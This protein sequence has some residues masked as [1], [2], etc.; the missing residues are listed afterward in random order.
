MHFKPT[1][2]SYT[3]SLLQTK[4]E[5]LDYFL[6]FDR[7]TDKIISL[8]NPQVEMNIGIPNTACPSPHTVEDGQLFA[9][10]CKLC[11]EITKEH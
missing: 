3:I 11:Y 5:V 4:E 10:Y 8:N 6:F 1:L 9:N 2:S 7:L